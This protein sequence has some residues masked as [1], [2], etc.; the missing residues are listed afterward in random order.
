MINN[1]ELGDLETLL[2]AILNGGLEVTNLLN[3]N[4]RDYTP[5]DNQALTVIDEV[6]RLYEVVKNHNEWVESYG[7]TQ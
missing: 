1:E 6:D 4:C 2:H 7:V 3:K 5:Q